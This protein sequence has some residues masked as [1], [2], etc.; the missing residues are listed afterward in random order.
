M[1]SLRCWASTRSVILME[2][3]SVGVVVL[4]FFVVLTICR[5]ERE[6][7]PIVVEL[8]DD[9]PGVMVRR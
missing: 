8:R 1:Q 6:D 9:G 5:R 4:L 7:V 2:L 3:V